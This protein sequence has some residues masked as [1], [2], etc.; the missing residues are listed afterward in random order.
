[1]SKIPFDIKWKPQIES[2]EYKVETDCKEPVTII[3]WDLK[4]D[5][6]NILCYYFD[7]KE[8]IPYVTEGKDLFIITPEEELSE[9]EGA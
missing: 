3:K 1:M 8:D 9:F 7:G 4:N 5:N 2:G 6:G